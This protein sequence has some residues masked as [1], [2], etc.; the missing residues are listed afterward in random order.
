MHEVASWLEATGANV[1]P[2]DEPRLFQLGENTLEALIRISKSVDAAVFIFAEDDKIWY[3]TDTVSQPRDNVM[4]EYG[5]FVGI[6]GPKRAIV[7]RSGSPKTAAD[8]HG[9]TS[10]DVSPLK[11]NRAQIVLKSWAQNLGRANEDRAVAEL[12][13]ERTVLR[14]QLEIANEQLAFAEGKF[15]D[16]QSLA[17]AKGVVDF[18]TIDLAIDGHWKLLFDILYFQGVVASLSQEFLVPDDIYDCLSRSGLQDVSDKLSFP[19]K[20]ADYCL[21][22]VRKLLRRFRGYE[23]PETF[24]A[25]LW[26]LPESRRAEIE[27]LAGQRTSEARGGLFPTEGE[28]KR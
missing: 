20:N 24:L 26:T 14:N 28:I 19:R 16:L 4:I 23:K 25:F 13:L 5:L 21:T 18:S 8:L 11:I 27:T 6:L 7:A 9:I 3:R 17:Q 10:V 2:W 1:V 22:A 12:L 15:A